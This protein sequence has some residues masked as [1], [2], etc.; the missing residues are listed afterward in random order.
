MV[1]AG[2]G[3][4]GGLQASTDGRK[5]RPL[6]Y[7]QH[8]DRRRNTCPR[9]FSYNGDGLRV[10]S[11][12][13]RFW[14][15]YTWD[16]ANGLPVV[17]QETY[18]EKTKMPQETRSVKTYVYGL[19]LTSVY[20]DD[21]EHATT[22]QDYY[23]TDGLGSTVT[24]ARD[25]ASSETGAYAY[26]AFGEVRSESGVLSTDFL[27]AGEQ[28]DA[29]RDLY[30]LRARYY[31]PSTGRFLTQ[32]PL[33]GINLYTY[34]WNDPI[35]LVDPLGLCGWTDPWDCVP[36]PPIPPPPVP[37]G[38]IGLVPTAVGCAISSECR[39]DVADWAN[40]VAD[41]PSS[42]IQQTAGTAVA[43]FSSGDVSRENGVTFYENC[44]G[45][46]SFLRLSDAEAITLGHD[47]FA[48]GPIDPELKRHELTHVGQGDK[49]GLLWP[50]AY[51]WEQLRHG[52][53]CNR[54]EEEARRVA[55]EPL[56]CKE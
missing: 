31:D 13:G 49:Y 28:R 25:S 33:P 44:W 48:E 1:G 43:V 47:I 29:E 26:D 38:P 9:K 36:V 15:D 14:T 12:L 41:R 32:D 5:A 40:T 16:V 18:R 11:E 56:R 24:L 35:N 21:L 4:S 8:N 42:V 37:I 6:R 3:C 53:G 50:F 54:F 17:L 34:V 51:G 22:A 39:S 23:F 10:T 19:D 27:F 52:Y 46:C 45:A 20:T 7:I 2:A 30:Y 55:G